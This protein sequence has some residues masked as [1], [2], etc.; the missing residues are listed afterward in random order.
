LNFLFRKH[1][2]QQHDILIQS[3]VGVVGIEKTKLI[4][5]HYKELVSEILDGN[6]K[7]EPDW[8]KIDE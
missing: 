1:I 2:P 6:E 8:E 4:I 3:M 5:K 7:Y